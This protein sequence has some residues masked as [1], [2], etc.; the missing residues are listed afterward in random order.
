LN[1]ISGQV[2]GAVNQAIMSLQFQDMVTQLLGHVLRRLDVLKDVVAD[3]DRMAMALRDSGDP[4]TT[5][6]TLAD[7]RAHVDMLAQ[8]LG[9][10][11]QGV[12]NNPVSQTG[13]ASGDVELF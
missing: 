11:K 9:A 6:Q 2:E 10:L 8:K 3:E 1:T 5:L 4:A 7:L 12:K 13:Y